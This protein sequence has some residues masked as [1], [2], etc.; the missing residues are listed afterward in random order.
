MVCTPDNDSPK[1]KRGVSSVQRKVPPPQSAP[2]KSP[3]SRFRV[4]S[5]PASTWKRGFGLTLINSKC[6]YV[7][8]YIHIYICII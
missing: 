5:G 7:S 3:A 1:N 6:V 8:T 4:A 2:I